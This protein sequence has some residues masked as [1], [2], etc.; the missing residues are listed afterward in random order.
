MGSGDGSDD[1]EADGGEMGRCSRRLGELIFG[2]RPRTSPAGITGCSRSVDQ[3]DGFDLNALTGMEQGG[4]LEKRGRG[5]GSR[6]EFVTDLSGGREVV[7]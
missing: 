6:D 3:R 2:T 4:N 5:R 7:H 1:A